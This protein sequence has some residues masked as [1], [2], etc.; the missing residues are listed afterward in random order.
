M[1]IIRGRKIDEEAIIRWMWIIW[2]RIFGLFGISRSSFGPKVDENA[3]FS[4]D[5]QNETSVDIEIHAYS[6]GES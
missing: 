5:G 3:Y 4:V 1:S 6:S 2:N